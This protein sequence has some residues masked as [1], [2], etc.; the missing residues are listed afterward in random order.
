MKVLVLFGANINER[1]CNEFTPLDLAINN[2][3]MP[4]I[5]GLLMELGAKGSAHLIHGHFIGPPYALVCPT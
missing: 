3:R 2:A 5:E 4:K 1:G